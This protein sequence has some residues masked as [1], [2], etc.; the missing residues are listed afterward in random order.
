MRAYGYRGGAVY[1]FTRRGIVEAVPA[2]RDEASYYSDAGLYMAVQRTVFV[3]FEKGRVLKD[4]NGKLYARFWQ[5]SQREPFRIVNH[6]S[7]HMIDD[8]VGDFSRDS[9]GTDGDH[10]LSNRA[11]FLAAY[12]AD[13]RR[14]T[15][16]QNRVPRAEITRMGYYLPQAFEGKNLGGLRDTPDRARREV[17]AELWAEVHGYKSNRLS[18]AFPDAYIVVKE[19]NDFLKD[20]HD[21]RPVRCVYGADGR[22][23]P[24]PPVN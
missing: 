19:I 14:L 12:E 18:T 1:T 2:L 6:E 7:G 23:L 22:A 15:G 9:L 3:P 13:L 21:K 17:F 11:D 10:R 24:A 5:P 8:L 20:L 16:P 4:G